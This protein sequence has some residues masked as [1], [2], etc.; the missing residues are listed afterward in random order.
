MILTGEWL[1]Q[2]ALRATLLLAGL[3]A[4]WRFLPVSRPA[5]RRRLL[6]IGSTAVLISPWLSG[7]WGMDFHPSDSASSYS[8]G[9]AAAGVPWSFILTGLWITGSLTLGL[10]FYLESAALQR[11]IRQA[12]PWSGSPALTGL[13]LLES[14]AVSGPCV[15]CGLSPVLLL[16]PTAQQWTPDQWR[17]VLAHEQQHLRQ[18][19]L[20]LS[21]LPRLVQCFF[22]WH[23]LTPW[24][25]R[26]FHAES[27][28][29]CD[30]AV[31]AES[32]QGRRVYVEFL[33]SLDA[34]RLPAPVAAMGLKSS[35]GQR[36]ERLLAPPATAGRWAGSMALAFLAGLTVCALS[37]RTLP[38]A[39]TASV[40][41][42][43]F[44]AEAL[45]EADLRL[46]A[47]PFPGN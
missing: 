9:K 30:L 15:A 31:L 12:R 41:S 24:L 39:E 43:A 1:F 17:M 36:L 18:S 19:D 28:A 25:K 14:S 13:P 4:A 34:T 42:G 45:D 3:Y 23:P 2:A 37:L 22:W 27:E 11:L 29:L 38:Q 40:H 44:P 10:R 46:T 26:Q 8:P 6:L 47:E 35:L 16:P 7:W 32:G 21:W 20:L 5:L 33:L